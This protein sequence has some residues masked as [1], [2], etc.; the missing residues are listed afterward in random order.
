MHK[1]L[2]ATTAMSFWLGSLLIVGNIQTVHGQELEWAKRAGAG[3]ADESHAIAVD[4]A[5][6]SYVT[7]A[8]SSNATFGPGE[9]S[10]TT[11]A[12]AGVFVAKY[13][14]ADQLQWAKRAGGGGKVLR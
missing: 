6:N 7:G 2:G 1:V 11:L 5:G 4:G 3:G 14:S 9:A 12:N 13:D 8:F 10:E